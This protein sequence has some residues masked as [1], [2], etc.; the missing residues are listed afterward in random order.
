MPVIREA[1]AVLRKMSPAEFSD[2]C[3]FSRCLST[4]IDQVS[5]V[6]GLEQSEVDSLTPL[7][8]K[9]S[10]IKASNHRINSEM[11]C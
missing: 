3:V 1:L 7:K 4:L 9:T 6:Y 5:Q 8:A 11:C 10:E 2:Q